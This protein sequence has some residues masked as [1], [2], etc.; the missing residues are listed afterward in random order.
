MAKI[1]IK[2][3]HPQLT[4]KVR[5]QWRD[6]FREEQCK[7]LK[8]NYAKGLMRLSVLSG[9]SAE[10]TAPAD[11]RLDRFLRAGIDKETFFQVIIQ[12][13]NV[14]RWLNKQKMSVSSLVID[15]EYMYINQATNELFFLYIPVEGAEMKGNVKGFLEMLVFDSSFRVNVNTDFK[16]ELMNLINSNSTINTKVL[17]QYVSRYCP[18][19]SDDI[20]KTVGGGSRKLSYSKSEYLRQVMA[21]TEAEQAPQ[22]EPVHIPEERTYKGTD[23]FYDN[24][25]SAGPNGNG[26]DGTIVLGESDGTV[27][28]DGSEGTVMLD[29]DNEGTVM[30]NDDNE[31]T[32]VLNGD[33][34]GTVLLDESGETTLLKDE[35]YRSHVYPKLI[36]QKTGSVVTV[37]KPVF[38]I[39][40]EEGVVDYL[41]PDNTTI[42][43]T[44]ADIISRDGRYYLYDNNST[45]RSYV[46]NII[47]EP[48]KNIEIYDGTVIRLSD[49]EFEFRVNNY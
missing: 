16:Q 44:H 27:L 10:F 39:G 41:I 38:R 22:K 40:K 25:W 34:E 18:E 47:V 12:F 32:V 4:I 42:S 43:R 23:F 35:N 37:N 19:L 28:L 3:I 46:N 45:N 24:T 14:L 11:M 20:D 1:R 9:K 8:N 30:L 5:L 17:E 33:S 15:P 6:K 21:K 48:L 31:G 7:L 49:E 26:D 13:I 29:D 2:T 36:R